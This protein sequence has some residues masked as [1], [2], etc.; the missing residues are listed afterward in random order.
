MHLYLH[1]KSVGLFF[2]IVANS[3]SLQDNIITLNTNMMLAVVET[4]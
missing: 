3:L 1:I 4:N 2:Q